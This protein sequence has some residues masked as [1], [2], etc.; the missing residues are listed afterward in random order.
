MNSYLGYQWWDEETDGELMYP[1]K[2]KHPTAEEDIQNQMSNPDEAAG[3]GLWSDPEFLAN[4]T[5]LN[6][7]T[8]HTQFAD[9]HG[10]GWVFRAVFKKDRKGNLLDHT[11]RIVEPVTNEKLRAAVAITAVLKS[12]IATPRLSRPSKFAAKK[13]R[14]P[15]SATACRCICSTFTWKKACTASIAISRKTF[16]A[17]RGLQAKCGRRSKSSASIATA[18]RPSAPRCALPAR[19]PTRP[20]PTDGRDLT[21]AAHALRPPP[22]RA[23]W[24]TRSFRTRWSRKTCAGRSC[25]RPTRSTRTASITTS[26]RTWPRPC[27]SPP[28]ASWTGAGSPDAT[29]RCAHQNE[30]MSCIACHSSWNPSCFGC[31]L[32]QKA[33]KKMPNLHNEGDVSRNYVAYNFQTLRDDVFMLARDGNVTGNRIGPARSSCAI[34]V[35]SYN[36][37]RESIYVQQQTISAEGLSGIAFSTN[38]PHTVRGGPHRPTPMAARTSPRHQ[39]NQD[40]HRLPCLQ[41]ERQQRDHGPTADAGHELRELHRPLLLGRRRA[42][43]G[44]RRW[45]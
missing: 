24:A 32:P 10:H 39:R 41:A 14:W 18:R 15:T 34:H 26:T 43:E 12:R 31:H 21:L 13:P 42:N 7:K 2:Q 9:F 22:L 44:L 30:Q 1:A 8:R 33:N 19:R 29:K 40:V 11:G 37:N 27:A 17:T 23:R 5:D 45:R 6:T 16:T 25:R 3:R 36:A 20:R 35:G 38:V 28:T 4:L